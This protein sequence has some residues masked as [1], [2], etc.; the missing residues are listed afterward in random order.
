MYLS[1]REIVKINFYYLIQVFLKAFQNILIQRETFYYYRGV[2]V[3][4]YTSLIRTE[5]LTREA[6]ELDLLWPNE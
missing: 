2:S 5:R 4:Y 1:P 3:T 6:V